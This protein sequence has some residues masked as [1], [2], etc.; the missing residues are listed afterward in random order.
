M[1]VETL[2][3]DGMYVLRQKCSLGDEHNSCQA[4]RHVVTPGH[5]VAKLVVACSTVML[6]SQDSWDLQQAA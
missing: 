5:R 4:A 1:I 3:N 6:S 2:L